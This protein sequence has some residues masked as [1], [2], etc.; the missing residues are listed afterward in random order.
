MSLI[1]QY[2]SLAR[3][4]S[5]NELRDLVSLFHPFE[6]FPCV[7]DR[8]RLVYLDIEACFGDICELK[9][10]ASFSAKEYSEK[11]VTSA[12]EQILAERWA[13]DDISDLEDED[14]QTESGDESAHVNLCNPPDIC[15]PVLPL[16]EIPLPSS[17]PYMIRND[18]NLSTTDDE[19]DAEN[20]TPPNPPHS[21]ETED[22]TFWDGESTDYELIT[23]YFERARR[24]EPI[25]LKSVDPSK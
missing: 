23:I 7:E 11:E 17:N 21:N 3:H 6:I 1:L 16:P 14:S 15:S 8:S 22:A 2:V 20:Y 4:S 25:V 24:G 5:L 18:D 9:G 13:Y 10:S 12:L 19:S